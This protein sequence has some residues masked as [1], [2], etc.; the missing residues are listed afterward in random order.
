MSNYMLSTVD[1]PFN[2][3]V[4][5][6]EWLA[7]D[8][9]KGHNCCSLVDQAAF[10]SDGLPETINN[11]IIQQAI[12]DIVANDPFGLYMKVEKSDK[13]IGINLHNGD[14]GGG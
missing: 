9:R 10:T 12:D 11:D 3:F 7:Y 1:N 8:L 4:Q 5:W 6:D 14:I 2:P 13:V